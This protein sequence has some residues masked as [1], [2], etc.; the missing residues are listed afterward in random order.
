MDVL[1]A[2][3]ARRS[4]AGWLA[5]CPSHD[6][7][8]ASLKI[9]RA[10]H[11]GW[12]IHCHAG[13]SVD[14]V[15]AAAGLTVADIQPE[16]EHARQIADRYDY[17][18]EAGRPVYQ[19][20]RYLPKGFAQRRRDPVGGWV[21]KLD[22]VDRVLYRLDKIQ[23]K[24]AVFICEGEKDVA[25]IEALGLSATTNAGGAGPGKWLPVYTAQLVAA[26]VTRAAIL[27][28]NDDPGRAHALRIA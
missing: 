14:A 19:V 16:P 28:D 26:G 4:G 22:G 25:A 9:D 27:P 15:L 6:D 3:R 21:W 24:R 10:D 1:D 11:G 20:V 17:V 12:L 18:D 23:G 13:C 2:L 5:R 7:G 8:T